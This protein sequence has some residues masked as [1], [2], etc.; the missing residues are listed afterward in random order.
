MP[1]SVLEKCCVVNLENS[2]D[3]VVAQYNPNKVS[4]GKSMNWTTHPS[5]S[6]GADMLEFINAQNRILSLELFFDG[7][8]GG[9]NGPVNVETE[10]ID[11]LIAMT[12]PLYDQASSAASSKS[13]AIRPAFVMIAWGQMQSFRGVI[14]SLNYEYTMFLPNGSPIRA[15]ATL[16]LKEIDMLQMTGVNKKQ[17]MRYN[18]K[19][20]MKAA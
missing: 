6:G 16:K 12:V 9:G 19:R 11:K 18:M 14:E 15:T 3:K 7:L 1:S 4:I 2:G 13:T 8:E 17:Y 5:S 10:Y 20:A